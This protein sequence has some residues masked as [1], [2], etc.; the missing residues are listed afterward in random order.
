MA[1]A[2]KGSKENPITEKELKQAIQKA[3]GASIDDNEEDKDNEETN[4]SYKI[5]SASIKDDFCNY[6]CEITRGV[7]L[8]DGHDVDGKG[9]VLDDLKD[10][11]VKFRVHMAYVDGVFRYRGLVV[12]DIDAYH[13]DE[14]VS[15]YVVTGFKIYGSGDNEAIVL[16]GNKYCP[17]F[18]ERMKVTTPRIGM[19]NLSGYNWYNEIKAAADVAREKV[20]L[21][22]EGN[23][24]V[25][26]DEEDDEDVGEKK[27]KYG[28]Q[29]SIASPEAVVDNHESDK[30]RT[31]VSA[32]ELDELFE[33]PMN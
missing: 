28:K 13:D 19:D 22:K 14:F 32:D 2:K 24:I 10:A 26:K 15:H 33:N 29:L 21:Y 12:K 4:R 16:M 25:V 27:R 5:T 9:L 18:S 17:G 11:F 23:C 3:V 6:R 7:G 20:A 8:N 1:K 30:V 31:E